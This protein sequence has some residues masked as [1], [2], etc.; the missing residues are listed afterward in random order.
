MIIDSFTIS[1]TIIL[2]RAILTL[3]LRLHL[4]SPFGLTVS[5]TLDY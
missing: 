3:R 4:R 1:L 5:I 2:F